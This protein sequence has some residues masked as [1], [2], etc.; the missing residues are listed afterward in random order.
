[1]SLGSHGVSAYDLLFAGIRQLRIPTKEEKMKYTPNDEVVLAVIDAIVA[2][3]TA[4]FKYRGNE[5]PSS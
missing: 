1:M 2:I 5:T 4:Y 3:A